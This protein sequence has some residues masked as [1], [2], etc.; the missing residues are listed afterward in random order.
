MKRRFRWFSLA[1][2]VATSFVGGA[3]R[4]AAS[5]DC[6]DAY[7]DC[8][9]SSNARWQVD[10][11]RG[12]VSAWDLERPLPLWS[13][14]GVVFRLSPLSNEAISELNTTSAIPATEI[15]GRVYFFLNA[16]APRRENEKAESFRRQNDALLALDPRAQGRLVWICRAQDFASFFAPDAGA[17]HF[18]PRVEILSNDELLIV[19]Q[20]ERQNARSFAVDAATGIFRPLDSATRKLQ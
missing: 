8:Y 4:V 20:S 15:F 1:F 12:I 13:Q 5:H 9:I 7:V 10:R 19:V 3:S 16:S 18:V 17:L 11:R 14:D 6:S 2:A